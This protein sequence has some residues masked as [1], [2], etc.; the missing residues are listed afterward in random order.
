MGWTLGLALTVF[1]GIEIQSCA[2]KAGLFGMSDADDVIEGISAKG[3]DAL[4]KRLDNLIGFVAEK[5]PNALYERAK[6]REM[7]IKKGLPDYLRAQYHK[8]ETIRTL[9]KRDAPTEIEK[10]YVSHRFKQGDVE[11]SEDDVYKDI[12]ERLHRTIISGGAGSGKSVFLKRL[13]RAAIERGDTYYPI[14]FELRSMN[15]ESSAGLLDAIFDSIKKY[16][17]GLTRTQFNFCLSRGLFYLMIDALDEL[18]SAKKI[19]VEEELE[20]IGKKYPLCPLV[21]TSRPRKEFSSWE[22]FYVSHLQ[23]FSESQ[24]RQ[25]ISKVDYPSEKKDE[26]LEFLGESGFQRYS[27]FLSNPLLASMMLL[28]FEEFGQIPER[29]HVFY[30]KCFDVLLREH[31]SSKG[32]YRR[33]LSSGLDWGCLEEVFMY[34]CVFSYLERKFSFSEEE[35][36]EFLTDSLEAASIDVDVMLV[37]ADL[38]NAVSVIQED[39]KTFEFSHRSFQE[40]FYARYVSKDRD[41]SLC[42]KIAEIQ[43]GGVFDDIVYMIYDMGRSY[44]ENSFLRIRLGSLLR[45]ISAINPLEFPDRIV[46]KFWSHFSFVAASDHET[47]EVVDPPIARITLSMVHSPKNIRSKVPNL[48]LLDFFQRYEEAGLPEYPKLEVDIDTAKRVSGRDN[49][50]VRRALEFSVH[51]NNRDKMVELGLDDYAQYL[52]ECVVRLHHYLEAAAKKRS[53]KIATRL[54][55][56]GKS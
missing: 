35:L 44:F 40:Y 23:P 5:A 10:V 39:G 43:D 4:A 16:S 28:T 46:S 24:F 37:K 7:I 25:F 27:E 56:R 32:R 45:D 36:V 34:F 51:N 8:C 31:D 29:R 41:N 30:E 13:F 47:R 42:D 26:F 50:S 55:R 15:S 54:K 49:L 33:E 6:N 18:S 53:S 22:G 2:M 11:K 52:K 48:I 17:P 1:I 9:L 21:V 38:V 20:F 12:G 14:F 19:E 3:M